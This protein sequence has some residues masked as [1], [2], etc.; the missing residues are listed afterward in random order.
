MRSYQSITDYLIVKLLPSKLLLLLIFIIIV[1][2]ILVGFILEKL[3]KDNP[4][5]KPSK[6]TRESRKIR[7]YLPAVIGVAIIL[8][9]G[10]A[11]S[12]ASSFARKA[13]KTTATVTDV[14]YKTSHIK[15]KIK[16]VRYH[17]T[18]AYMDNDVEKHGIIS[19][20]ANTSLKTYDKVEIYYIPDTK[21]AI[22]SHS[23]VAVDFEKD[24]AME[25]LFIGFLFIVVGVLQVM[26]LDPDK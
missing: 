14:E 19:S 4:L 18:V 12:N 13:E 15:S 17:Y 25:L 6:D 9:G 21:E 11:L 26:F 2:P 23:I 24:H 20:N 7:L 3:G 8:I 5:V 22:Y 10:F 16:N 1:L